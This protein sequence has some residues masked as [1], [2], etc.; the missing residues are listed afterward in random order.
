MIGSDRKV[1]GLNPW[2]PQLHLSIL[3]VSLILNYKL[4]PSMAQLYFILLYFESNR[5]VFTLHC[6]FNALNVCFYKK[7]NVFVRIFTVISSMKKLVIKNIKTLKKNI[8]TTV[9]MKSVSIVLSW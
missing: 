3:R 4:A 8:K 5:I 1:T 9:A 2:L 7:K 6:T